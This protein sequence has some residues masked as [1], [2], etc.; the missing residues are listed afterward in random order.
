MLLLDEGSS[1]GLCRYLS[2]H[3]FHHQLLETLKTARNLDE[4]IRGNV[5][6]KIN[7]NGLTESN[8]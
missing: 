6:F 5:K 7:V 1:V 2:S 8:M 3:Q 4:F